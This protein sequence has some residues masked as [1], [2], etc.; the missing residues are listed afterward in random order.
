M[1]LLNG[2][3]MEARLRELLEET[4]PRSDHEEAKQNSSSEAE[5]KK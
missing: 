3:E 4:T 2:K 5:D 1:P